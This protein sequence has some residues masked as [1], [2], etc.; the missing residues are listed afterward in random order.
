MANIIAT[1][2]TTP[3]TICDCQNFQTYYDANINNP[4]ATS[5][6]SVFPGF[7]SNTQNKCNS[8]CASSPYDSSNYD[9]VSCYFGCPWRN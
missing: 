4:N 3:N 9:R 5:F 1:S 2:V 8:L 6:I 7:K